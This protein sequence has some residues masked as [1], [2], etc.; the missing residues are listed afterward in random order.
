MSTW[1]YVAEREDVDFDEEAQTLDMVFDSYEGTSYLEV[2]IQ[3]VIS[4]LEK[5]GYS[6]SKKESE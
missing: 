1:F 6:V 3:F 4:E 2:P 5:I